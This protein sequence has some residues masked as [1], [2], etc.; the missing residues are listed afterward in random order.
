MTFAGLK[1]CMPRTS[2]GRLRELRDR[3]DV[4]ARCV[5]G[6]DRTRLR[7]GIDLLKHSAFHLEVFKYGLNDD[8]GA[9]E[10][11]RGKSSAH[12]PATHRRGLQAESLPLLAAL[13]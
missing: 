4:E 2:A 13:S 9:G 12:E 3:V 7:H 11:R 1:K 8:V 10:I 5:G 6:E